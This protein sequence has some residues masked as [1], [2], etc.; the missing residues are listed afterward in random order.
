M[1]FTPF[2]IFS[3]KVLLGLL[4]AAARLEAAVEGRGMPDELMGPLVHRPLPP[5]LVCSLWTK[6]L[7]SHWLYNYDGSSVPGTKTALVYTYVFCFEL[8]AQARGP[9]RAGSA[10][11]FRA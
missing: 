4:Q 5:W 3:L 2:L 11:S 10:V 7:T 1:S 8:P 9:L 6:T